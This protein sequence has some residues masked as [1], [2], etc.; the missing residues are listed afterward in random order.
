MSKRK[1]KQMTGKPGRPKQVEI[2]GGTNSGHITEVER[3][4]TITGHDRVGGSNVGRATS[5]QRLSNRVGETEGVTR[6]SSRPSERK[7]KS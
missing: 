2:T 5:V 1:R 7:D 3:L 4:S 6:I